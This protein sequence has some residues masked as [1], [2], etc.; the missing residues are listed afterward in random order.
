MYF[1]CLPRSLQVLVVAG[2]DLGRFLQKE[3]AALLF[4]AE[5]RHEHT[6]SVE[7]GHV[8]TNWLINLLQQAIIA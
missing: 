3:L 7:T 1:P 2:L 8:P 4:R 6:S 5:H